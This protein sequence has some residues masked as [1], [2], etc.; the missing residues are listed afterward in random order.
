MMPVQCIA[1][2]TV[3][4]VK[5]LYKRLAVMLETLHSIYKGYTTMYTIYIQSFD[6]IKRVV[7]FSWKSV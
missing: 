3:I 6:M 1:M 2:G 7:S 5:T 4:F